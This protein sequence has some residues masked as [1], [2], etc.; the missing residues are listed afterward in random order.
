MTGQF[1]VI[2]LPGIVVGAIERAGRAPVPSGILVLAQ[3]FVSKAEARGFILDDGEPSD[4]AR[5]LRDITR[6]D[7]RMV[8]LVLS[9]S[10]AFMAR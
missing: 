3:K 2:A 6:K 4:N 5:E 1:T 8:E 7:S 9:E 10:R